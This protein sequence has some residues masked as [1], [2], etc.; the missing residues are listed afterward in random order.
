MLLRDAQPR[1]YGLFK[2]AF[3]VVSTL[4]SI[5]PFGVGM[6]AFYYLAR[7]RHMHRAAICNI[8]GFHALLGAVAFT[9][10]LLYPQV[11]SLVFRDG[12]EL[13]ANAALIGF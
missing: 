2:Q 13:V 12:P 8:L 3:L 9:V 6:S 1:E 10:L 11:L 4:V 7:E 5:L